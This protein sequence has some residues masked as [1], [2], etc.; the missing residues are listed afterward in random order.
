MEHHNLFCVDITDIEGDTRPCAILIPAWAQIEGLQV[1]PVI[2]IS[3][4]DVHVFIASQSYFVLIIPHNSSILL[5]LICA[6]TSLFPS[7][8]V[9]QALSLSLKMF[10]QRS[11]HST[12]LKLC[13]AFVPHM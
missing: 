10:H 7:G 4:V 12:D 11:C 2:K 3:V 8:T 1:F 5:N 13:L 6:L 9:L